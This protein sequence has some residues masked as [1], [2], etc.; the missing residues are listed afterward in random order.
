MGRPMKL[1]PG[2][3]EDIAH[4]IRL[5]ATLALA[6]KAVGVN[7]G[8]LQTWVKEGRAEAL[9][10]EQITEEQYE[11]DPS[12]IEPAV[13]KRIYY[14][15]YQAVSKAEGAAVQSWLQVIE[16]AAAQGNWFAAAWKLERR[17][18]ET[19]G[20]NVITHQGAG[21]GPIETRVKVVEVRKAPQ[22]QLPEGQEQLPA[23]RPQI[24]EVIVRKDVNQNENGHHD[25]DVIEG[26]TYETE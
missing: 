13:E 7:P 25:D 12:L 5:G 4:A 10:L 16:D 22:E 6:A 15:L 3:V 19:Y 24:P 1:N 26:E 2:L 20:K 11:A 18:P 21:G 8:T 23:P 14:E 9:R 17:H